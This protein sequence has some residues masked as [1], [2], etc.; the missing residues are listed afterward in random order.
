[1]TA[2]TDIDVF[3]N[4]VFLDSITAAELDQIDRAMITEARKRS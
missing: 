2:V 3:R 4:A 1:M